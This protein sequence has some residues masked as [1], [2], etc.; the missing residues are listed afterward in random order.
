MIRGFKQELDPEKVEY[1]NVGLQLLE[2]T[3]HADYYIGD[4][5]TLADLSCVSSV[6]SFD[7]VLPISHE[8]FFLF[9]ACSEQCLRNRQLSVFVDDFNVVDFR[10]P[11]TG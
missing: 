7:A 4:R 6:S 5:M 1:F 11:S 8:R 3:L 2:D 9:F 10:K